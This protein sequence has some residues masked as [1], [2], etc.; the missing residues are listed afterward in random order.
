M[1][2]LIRRLVLGA[3]LSLAG[4]PAGAALAQDWAQ[5]DHYRDANRRLPPPDP[6][7][8]RVV[9]FGDSITEGWNLEGLGL[10]RLEVLNRGIGGQTTPQMLI[11]FR[12]DVVHLKPA[13]V[14]IL[15]GTNDLA[16]NTGPTTLEAIEDNLAG[17]VEI[18]QAHHIRVVL[19]S[20]LPAIDYPWRPGLRPAPRIVALNA[21]MRAC[22][23]QRGLLYLDYHAAVVDPQQGLKPGL[24]DDG[25]HPNAAG[26]AALNPLAREAILA[27]LGQQ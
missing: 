8:P 2:Q 24:S 25:V 21:W 11:R 27:A 26:Y 5:L 12:Q 14:H 16:G 19:A 20:V 10:S 6:G 13:V 3:A 1:R 4:L 9:F 22:A 7:R 17:M 15:A 23:E 18:A